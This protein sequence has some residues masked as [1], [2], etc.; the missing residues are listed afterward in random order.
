MDCNSLLLA[1][2]L[3]PKLLNKKG[4][5]ECTVALKDKGEDLMVYRR[6]ARQQNISDIGAEDK[7]GVDAKHGHAARSFH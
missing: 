6:T 3:I 5:G 2:F 1:S 7:G 4:Y